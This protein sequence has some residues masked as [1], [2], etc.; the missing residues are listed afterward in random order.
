MSR[1]LSSFPALKQF[2]SR[3]SHSFNDQEQEIVDYINCHGPGY[4]RLIQ[5]KTGA[6]VC[7]DQ[8][9]V[10]EEENYTEYFG[11]LTVSGETHDV[12]YGYFYP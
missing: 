12:H 7:V 5:K 8:A 10:V 2:A 9:F 3:A 1:D 4:Y 11:L 6:F